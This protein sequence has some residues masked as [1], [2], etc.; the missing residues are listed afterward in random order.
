MKRMLWLIAVTIVLFLVAIILPYPMVSLC[1]YIAAYGLIGWDVLRK[2]ARNIIRGNVFDENFLMVI[3][4]LGALLLGEY[5]EAV[6]VMLLY[7]IGEMFQK[8]ALQNSRKSI[9]ALMNIRPEI[10]N[11]EKDGQVNAVS[12]DTI[13]IGDTIVIR[14]GERVPL[15]GIVLEGRSALD[16][17]ALTGESIPRDVSVGEEVISGCVN[18]SG[19]LRVSV[20]KLYQDSTV[21]KILDLVDNAARHKARSEA[22]ITRFAR[23]YTPVVCGAAV[24]L[25][26]IPPLLFGESLRVWGERALS[27]LVVSCPCAL[28]ISV[29]LTF[30][31]GI[32][33]ASR[34][35]I[36]VKGS[37]YFEMLAHAEPVVF[38]KTGTLT[39]GIFRVTSIHPQSMP[40]EELLH[41]AATLESFSTHPIAVSI[42]THNKKPL[43]TDALS[44]I[45][46]LQGFGLSASYEGQMYYIGNEALMA[47]QRIP[48]PYC[49]H[50]GTVVHL[51]RDGEYLG[52]IAISDNLKS[53]AKAAIQALRQEGVRST[54]LLTGDRSDIAQHT[55]D[56]LG[57]NQVYAN[58][59][60]ADKVTHVEELF[61]KQTDGHHLVFVGDGINDAPVL[62]RADV[63]VA[64]GALG[65]D[66]A[67]EA[68]DIV[69]MDDDPRKLPLAIRLARRTLR[70]ANQNIVFAIGIK[71]IVLVLAAM[72][73]A[74]MWMAVFA[75]VGVSILA[76]LNATRA[77]HTGVVQ[78]ERMKTV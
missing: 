76:I 46:D 30:F 51:A 71:T 15:D 70:I 38:D 2:A 68:A 27:F 69:L 33:G 73:I 3:A 63:G 17:A 20:T 39:E 56:M 41:L 1:L 32:G 48:I 75:D 6:A 7:Q 50:F 18:R 21:A 57:I 43:H 9:A 29:P 10:A 16:T 12:P 36:L 40:V 8:R 42:R 60:P 66:A 23:Y 61:A 19:L 26:F 72:G 59:L 52:H 28:V 37:N 35:G 53:T 44:D 55:A 58:L 78:T 4:T 31:G 65:S 11:L 22:F 64:M 62:A 77:L 5:P 74:D 45:T 14:P 25:A 54:I 24:L 47:Q 49:P 13:Q 67:V 34:N